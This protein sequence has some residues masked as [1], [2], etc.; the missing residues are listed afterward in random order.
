MTI[1]DNTWQFMTIHYNTYNTWQCVQYMTIRTMLY[2]TM[3][4][5][6]LH[7]IT[8]QLITFHYITLHDITYMRAVKCCALLGS[9]TIYLWLYDYVYIYRERESYSHVY[10]WYCYGH[11]CNKI[12]HGWS[13]GSWI[14]LFH[15]QLQTAVVVG[16]LQ[17]IPDLNLGH[18]TTTLPKARTW[19]CVALCFSI[20]ALH[21][22]IPLP[23]AG[24]HAHDPDIP[25]RL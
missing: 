1:H 17:S 11:L 19:Q 9:I 6:K 16:D 15:V 4:G 12:P 23:I 20:Q 2:N 8:L 14:D 10:V 22:R 13:N 25:E 5:H 18:T 24:A 21:W 7:H 3:Q